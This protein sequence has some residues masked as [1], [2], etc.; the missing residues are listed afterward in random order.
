MLD[1]VFLILIVNTVFDTKKIHNIEGITFRFVL[2]DI[3]NKAC[4]VHIK[5]NG[6]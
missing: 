5:A 6:I 3:Y 4:V 2:Q 1:F